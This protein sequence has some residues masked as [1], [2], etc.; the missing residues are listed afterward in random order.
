M[1]QYILLL[2][3]DPSGFGKLTPE[4][5]RAAELK[6]RE[7]ITRPGTV[8]AKRLGNDAGRVVRPVDGTAQVLDGPYSE[9]KEQLAGFYVIEAGSYEEA[10]EITKG[11]P[12]VQ[13]GGTV[14]VRQLWAPPQS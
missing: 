14:E 11:H 9:T 13:F 5:Q 6:Y 7:W 12:H 8:D 4:Q 3:H 10:V 1:P 2:H